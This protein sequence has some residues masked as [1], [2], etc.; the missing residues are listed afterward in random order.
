MGGNPWCQKV[1]NKLAII[2]IR[3]S[4]ILV[5]TAYEASDRKL[6]LFIP[7]DVD[8]I[9]FGNSHSREI[10]LQAKDWTSLTGQLVGQPDAPRP[11][12]SKETFCQAPRIKPKRYY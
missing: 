7:T 2:L 10:T 11:E 5:L 8:A 9:D 1:R 3:W 6:S 12:F 4:R